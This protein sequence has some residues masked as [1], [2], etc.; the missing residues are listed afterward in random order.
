MVRARPLHIVVLV[1]DDVK[2]VPTGSSGF[3]IVSLRLPRPLDRFDV[4]AL[5][6]NRTLLLKSFGFILPW[7][8]PFH[9]TGKQTNIRVRACRWHWYYRH[10]TYG[11]LKA[12]SR[13]WL[14]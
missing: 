8:R 13:S 1:T 7:Q 6:H 12:H 3:V 11:N 14:Q 4:V 2:T 10:C 9:V 5:L